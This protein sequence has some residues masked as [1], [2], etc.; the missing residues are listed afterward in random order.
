[1]PV[2][3]DGAAARPGLGR[4]QRVP[5]LA[6]AEPLGACVKDVRPAADELVAPEY[7]EGGR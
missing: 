2:R 4:A 7:E 6:G 5:Q 1:M 3:D